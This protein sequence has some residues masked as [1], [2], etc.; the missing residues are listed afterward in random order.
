MLWIVFPPELRLHARSGA[1]PLNPVDG[2]YEISTSA[3]FPSIAWTA[4][5]TLRRITGGR[6]NRQRIQALHQHGP[7]FDS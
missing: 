4:A 5:F 1:T 2:S 7:A 6:V 3:V